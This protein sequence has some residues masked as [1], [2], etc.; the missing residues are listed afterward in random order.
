MG[1]TERLYRIKHQLDAGRCLSKGAVA[2][3]AVVRPSQGARGLKQGRLVQHGVV[4]A[5]CVEPQ[6]TCK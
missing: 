5:D 2:G 4:N 6:S 3:P 1:Q